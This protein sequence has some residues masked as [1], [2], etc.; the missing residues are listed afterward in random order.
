MMRLAG[1]TARSM[2]AG[3]RRGALGRSR[4]A[5]GRP[6]PRRARS[7]DREAG[8]RSASWPRPRRRCPCP[9]AKTVKLRPDA[10]LVTSRGPLPFVDGPAFVTGKAAYGADIRLPGML[11]A[12]IARPPV[13]GGRVHEPRRHRRRWPCRAC[14]RSSACP[15]SSLPAKF[16]PLGGVAVVADHTWAAL[17]GRKALVV[18]WDDGANAAYDS[19]AY[20]DD[21][22]RRRERAGQGRPQGGRRRAS[23]RRRGAGCSRPS[24]TCRTSSTTPMEP[25]AAVARVDG[26]RVRGLGA[27]AGP[28]DRPGGGRDGARH[29]AGQGHAST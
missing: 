12:V 29:R 17:Q 11:T 6:R 14:A 1:A 7:R 23:T 27:D 24:T 4:R 10:E 9:D 2:L 8:R 20:R 16:Q 26:E 3:R 21:A 15:S 25:P 19:E 22:A 28:A 13:V 5:P 18:E